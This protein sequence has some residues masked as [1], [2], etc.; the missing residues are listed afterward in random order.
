QLQ[1]GHAEEISLLKRQVWLRAEL[2]IGVNSDVEGGLGVDRIEDQVV[3]RVQNRRGAVEELDNRIAEV[4]RL[5]H[6]DIVLD[7]ELVGQV[8]SYINWVARAVVA[9]EMVEIVVDATVVFLGGHGQEP[10]AL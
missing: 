6:L 10:G 5:Q 4:P 9:L 1:A 2:V 3:I 8:N 7:V